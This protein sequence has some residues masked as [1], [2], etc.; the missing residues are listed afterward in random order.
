MRQ[1][2]LTRSGHIDFDA[3]LLDVATFE[4][5]GARLLVVDFG[6]DSLRLFAV[7]NAVV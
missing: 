2:A 7:S 4:I 6:D 5:G 1:G 3:A